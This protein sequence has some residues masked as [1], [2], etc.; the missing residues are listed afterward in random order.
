MTRTDQVTRRSLH[1]LESGA[2]SDGINKN[3][4]VSDWIGLVPANR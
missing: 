4:L 3:E 2:C 1:L